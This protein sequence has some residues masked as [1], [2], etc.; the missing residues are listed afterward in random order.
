[1]GYHASRSRLGAGRTPRCGAGKGG[2]CDEVIASRIRRRETGRGE[3]GEPAPRVPECGRAAHTNGLRSMAGRFRLAR[4]RGEW[5][6]HSGSEPPESA[7]WL[8]ITPVIASRIPPPEPDPHRPRTGATPCFRVLFRETRGVFVAGAAMTG[9]YRPERRP[10]AVPRPSRL[11]WDR[12]PGRLTAGHRRLGIGRGCTVETAAGDGEGGPGDGRPLTCPD[13]P[14]RSGGG[15]RDDSV[16]ALFEH[17]AVSNT[18]GRPL[19]LPPHM[20]IPASPFKPPPTVRH[21]PARVVLRRIPAPMRH[22]RSSG[23]STGRPGRH[24]RNWPRKARRRKLPSAETSM[25]R[26]HRARTAGSSFRLSTADRKT[27]T[28]G[29]PAAVPRKRFSISSGSRTAGGQ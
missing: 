11:P 3:R 20:G 27:A 15:N 7:V 26:R 17:A 18:G 5:R 23:G 24:P 21:P 14:P 13:S 2:N 6:R 1:M 16:L 28:P 12:G 4:P 29:P 25:P 19:V 9:A 10:C 8:A 22:A